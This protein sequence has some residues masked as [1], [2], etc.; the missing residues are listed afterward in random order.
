MK[1]K[2]GWKTVGGFLRDLI[3]IYIPEILFV[4]M[5]ISFVLG[6]VFRYVFKNPQTWT[7]ELST[8]CYLAVAVLA[9]GIAQKTDDNVV[10]D[11]LYNKLSMKTKCIL[12]ILTNVAIT[13]VAAILIIPSITY[14]QS[15][16][17]LTAQ[18]LPIPRWFIFV[19]FTIAFVATT[20]RSAYRA[21]LDIK[22]FVRK[23]YIKNYGAKEDGAI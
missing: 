4:I 16:S 10:F 3:E 18:V 14:L 7:F 5:F 8:I 22:A 13:V 9:F 2:F 6:V 21:V 23:D 11:M 19:P 12:R 17:G 20:A 15:M 1:K